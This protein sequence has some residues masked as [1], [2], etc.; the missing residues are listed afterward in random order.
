[1]ELEE[2][3]KR[4]SD[5]EKKHD[6]LYRE[7][8]LLK[9][10]IKQTTISKFKLKIDLV[11]EMKMAKMLFEMVLSGGHT[12]REKEMIAR[13]SN[14]ILDLNIDKAEQLIAKGINTDDTLPF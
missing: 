10:T 6:S 8:I 13:M 11:A 12:H 2:L 5:L 4:Y 3:K 7:N 1:M 14:N 9:D